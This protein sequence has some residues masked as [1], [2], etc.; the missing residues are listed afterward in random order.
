MSS[1]RE[2][3]EARLRA[4]K[5]R[6]GMKSRSGADK[7]VSIGV[8]NLERRKQSFMEKTDAR[9]RRKERESM[10]VR[11]IDDK[12][13]SCKQK[14]DELKSKREEEEKKRDETLWKEIDRITSLVALQLRVQ[15]DEEKSKKRKRV[16]KANRKLNR[17]QCELVENTWSSGSGEDVLVDKFKVALKRKKFRCLRDGT[18]LNDEVINFYMKILQE[19]ADTSDNISQTV[20]VNNSFFFS[21]L[22]RERGGYNFK[23][24]RRWT[25]KVSIFDKDV[26][27]VPINQGNTHWTSAAIFI[28]EKT[29]RY[30]D[31]MAGNGIAELR[32]LRKYLVDEWQDKKE[33]HKLDESTKPVPEDWKLE[34]TGRSVPQQH[35][36]CDCGVFTCAFAHCVCLGLP[37]DFSQS[38]MANFRRHIGLSI[39]SNG[40]LTPDPFD[41]P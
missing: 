27:F 15:E 36:G 24:V 25:R 22:C 5:N 4:F 34:V 38:K 10:K 8:K 7:T 12:I 31:S 26:V 28:K 30:Y 14:L 6:H 29:I 37:F 16:K 1:D 11:E 35:N 39:L 19:Y 33:R 9:T 17:A 13:E 21:K 41:S 32:T 2:T 3:F 40:V 20:F 18:W 23:N